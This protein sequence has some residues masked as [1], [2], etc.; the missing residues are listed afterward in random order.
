MEKKFKFYISSFFIS[1]LIVFGLNAQ[2]PFTGLV[3]EQLNNE[4]SVEGTTYRIY[5]ELS[6]G[7]LYAIYANEA[8]PSLLETT[9]SFF[10]DETF[11]G[12][13]Q[14][15]INTAL[16]DSY[17][18]LAFDTW[19]TIGESYDDAVQ[20]IGNLNINDFSTSQWSFGGSV[21]SDASIFRTPDNPYCLPDQLGLVLL[22]QF[23]TT[24]TLSGYL[25]LRIQNDAG[26][27]FES[28]SY[29]MISSYCSA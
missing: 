21:N 17:P 22:G 7:K 12:D 13:F 14:T 24:G 11:G 20:T 3:L 4:Q 25:N 2:S 23:T 9:T 29:S 5:A 8:N 16:F 6:E 18:D 27:V 10:N 26:D 28:R 15:D 19:V 1:F